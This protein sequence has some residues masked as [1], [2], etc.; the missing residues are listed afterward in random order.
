LEK[1]KDFSE[2]VKFIGKLIA[3]IMLK[4]DGLTVKLEYAGGELVRAS[5]RG[6]GSEGED[7]THNAR[8]F[9][10]V[11]LRIPFLGKL[12]VV[13]EAHIL[14][15]DFKILQATTTGKDGKTYKNARNLAAGSVRQ[16]DAGECAK[17]RIRFGAFNVLVAEGDFSG[18]SVDPNS[19]ISMLRFIESMGFNI[20]HFTAIDA[21]NI[22][23]FE[24]IVSDLQTYAEE[25][26]I[27]I[28]GLVITYDDVAHSKSLGRTGHHYRDGRALKFDDEMAETVLRQ[29][30]WNVSRN[31]EL[32]PVA[33]F[34]TVELEG[35]EVSRASLHNPKFI[36]DMRLNLGDRIRVC[37]RNMIIPHVEENLSR[38]KP[39]NSAANDILPSICPCCESKVLTSL[40]KDGEPVLSCT[41]ENC[42]DRILRQFEHFVSRKVMNIDGLSEATLRKFIDAGL[43]TEKVDIFN[44]QDHKSAIV[45]MEGF[46]EKAFRRLIDSI[47][48]S[49]TTTMERFLIAMD[50]SNLGRHASAILCKAFD[51]DIEKIKAAAMG[52]FDFTTLQDFGD[53]LHQN[54]KQWF[55]EEKNLRR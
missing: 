35:T 33:I 21:K 1:T 31:G 44:L 51:Y 7:I 22:S 10:N 52:D 19:K 13:G 14:A 26:G 54:I 28:D 40:S 9:T 6:D 5:T 30:E 24:A 8:V 11:P 53:I 41:N 39:R 20:A 17:R 34:D 27:P 37:K 15:D 48:E 46:G 12:T 18:A 38:D 32:A 50:I 42:P 55:R 49:R 4:L 16:L 47:E 43:L 3:L 23:E 29:V 45:A 2:V 36:D 25:N